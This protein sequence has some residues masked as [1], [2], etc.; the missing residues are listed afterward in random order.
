VDENFI[1]S[2]NALTVNIT[3]IKNKLSSLGVENAIKT[4]RG[5]GYYFDSTALTGDCDD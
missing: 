3:R 1:A 2:D 5:V 4:K